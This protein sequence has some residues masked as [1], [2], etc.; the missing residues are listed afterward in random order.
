MH[1]VQ[2][3][4]LS[5]FNLKTF[6]KRFASSPTGCP[7]LGR[8]STALYNYPFAQA[9]QGDFILCLKD[10]NQTELVRNATV[11]QCLDNELGLLEQDRRGLGK[12]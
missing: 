6:S 4:P 1:K 2:R 9:D 11:T 5:S 12:H 7:H 3:S 10:T 8:L